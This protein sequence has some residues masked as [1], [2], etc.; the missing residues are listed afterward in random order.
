MSVSSYQRQGLRRRFKMAGADHALSF[1]PNQVKNCL[2]FFLLEFFGK[3]DGCKWGFL[4]IDGYNCTRCTHSNGDPERLTGTFYTSSFYQIHSSSCLIGGT[5]LQL[6]C[7]GEAR[8][9]GK[10]YCIYSIKS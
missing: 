4:E 1:Q 5:L 2:I 8:I 7:L 3:T 9:S 10:V 6:G